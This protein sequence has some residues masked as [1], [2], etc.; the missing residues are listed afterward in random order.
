M[1]DFDANTA[2]AQVQH[3]AQPDTN[4]TTPNGYPDITTPA[5]TGG[6]LSAKHRAQLIE[7]SAISEEAIAARG[8][9]TQ[10]DKQAIRL[11]GFE[12]YQ[13][14]PPSLVIPLYNWRRECTGYAL[15]P[16]IARKTSRGNAV[17]Y[18]TPKDASPVLDIAPLTCD[19][20]ADGSK[21]LILT[22]GARKAD[23]AA[24]RG[25]CAI[26]LS[27]VYG[28]RD[29]DTALPD[30]ENIQLN[31]R[32]VFIAYDSDVAT[33]P[34][35]ELALRRL[36]PFLQS[37]RAVVKICYLP[38]GPNGEKTG[39]DDFFARGGTVEELF[40]LARDLEPVE[41]T[42][43]K[44]KEAAKVEKMARLSAD[45]KP[46]IETL[47]RPLTAILGDLADAIAR[48]N[49][50]APRAFH[51][52][53]GLREIAKTADGT[54]VLE[55]VLPERLQVIADQAAAWTSTPADA[56]LP[57]EIA[58]PAT[59][60][61]QFLVSRDVWKNV[62]P[63]RRILTAPFVDRHGN[64][65]AMPG[66]H[67]AEAVWLALP[68]GFRLPDTNPT[69]ENIAAAK[70]LLLDQLL[71][72]VAFADDASRANALALMILPFM[73][74]YIEAL[75]EG[76]TPIHL[77]DAPSQSSGKTYA[78]TVCLSPF[79]EAVPTS[80]KKDEKESGKEVF[81]LLI[82]GVSY[83]FIDNVKSALGSPDIATAVTSGRMRNRVLGVSGT[84]TV[85]SNVVWV[86]TSNNAALEAD[87]VS[88]SILIR[89]DTN[90]ETPEDHEY[91]FNP[92]QY[93]AENRADVQGAILTLVR[94]W[95]E[96]GRPNRA[97]KV[98][99]FPAW[100]RTIGGILEVAGVPGFL[101][102]HRESRDSADPE[103]SA[104]CGFI[105]VWREVHG[106]R[107]VTAKELYETARSTDLGA[108]IGDKQPTKDLG[109]MLQK[110]RDKVIGGCKILKKPVKQRAGEWRLEFFDVAET[111][112]ETADEMPESLESIEMELEK[113]ALA[114][115]KD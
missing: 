53:D 85:D 50:D 49:G 47:D 42:K 99:R 107:F 96:A 22:E 64:I 28:F 51:G 62:P 30:W 33:K 24:S 59:L 55:A 21:P 94:A 100:E 40:A 74:Q 35:V 44:K 113:A 46:I 34:Q 5:I 81:A 75:N 103:T 63:I 69:P 79:C 7:E 77:F 11:L 57:R 60:C 89:L 65:C 52:T 9:F 39:L 12:K 112:D 95:L 106:R 90:S 17:K 68:D 105:D 91:S 41:E 83:I 20:I 48:Y 54:T 76:Q 31:G 97:K 13:A 3:G 72:E 14:L 109:N 111:G 80:D 98:S 4:G 58:P 71:S 88:R 10:T 32:A 2:A 110:R 18:E 108:L 67:A 56:S 29:K 38:A 82:E 8:Y 93:I 70:S 19:Q 102:N 86:A 92:L 78:A 115:G 43:R 101:E 25:L 114:Y 66:Y 16:D 104:W 37:R 45:G 23:S 27:G 1:S 6:T 15:R 26:N 87:T 84:H 61:R 73:R 36:C